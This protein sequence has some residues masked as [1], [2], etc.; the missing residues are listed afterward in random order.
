M[1]DNLRKVNISM[2]RT[3]EA[4]YLHKT[5]TQAAE[6]L[7]I[8]QPSVSWY[9]KQLRTLTGDDLF[10]RTHRGL[11]PTDFCRNYYHQAKEILNSLE[12]LAVYKNE[13]FDP[14]SAVAEFSVAIPF[15]KSHML[16]EGLSVN[17]M[18]E[19]PSLRA[20]LMH[21]EESDAIRHLESGLL[22]IYIGLVSEKLTKHFS[23]EKVLESEFIV[24]CSDKSKFF[25]KGKVSKQDY[26][27]TPHIKLAGGFEPSI[28]DIKLKQNGLLQKELVSVPDIASEII[29]LR[30]TAFL[31]IIDKSDIDIMMAGNN[32]KVLKTDFELPQLSPLCRL[33]YAQEERPRP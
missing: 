24:L 12:L 11:E 10:I 22:D 9:L 5:T 27:N 7:G 30:E 25:K 6:K 28:L 19:Y 23:S 18:N 1:R 4:L 31:L 33:A 32:F 29:L 8:A 13:A 3:L 2:L 20:N 15:V 21:F 14:K 16:V 26:I 17:V